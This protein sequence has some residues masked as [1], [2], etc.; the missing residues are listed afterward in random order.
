MHI[1]VK[2]HDLRLKL[3]MR[4]SARLTSRMREVMCSRIHLYPKKKSR[5]YALSDDEHA[6]LNAV[7]F[8]LRLLV[9]RDSAWFNILLSVGRETQLP[10]H[11]TN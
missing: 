7:S 5:A 10:T 1:K 3:C 9:A 8:L 2:S 4:L 11:S 6:A